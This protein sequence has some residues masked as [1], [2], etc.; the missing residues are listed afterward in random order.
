MKPIKTLFTLAI[1]ICAYAQAESPRLSLSITEAIGATD[2]RQCALPARLVQMHPESWKKKIT[3]QVTDADITGWDPVKGIWNVS[4]ASIPAPDIARRVVDRCFIILVDGKPVASG[5]ALWTYSARLMRMPVLGVSASADSVSFRLG[6]NYASQSS[7][8][9][10]WD[11]INKA[12]E[13]K[14]QPASTAE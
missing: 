4:G 5:V 7:M 11:A 2:A 12:L 9:V 6:A 1:L 8:P 10:V 13:G 14:P 3:Y